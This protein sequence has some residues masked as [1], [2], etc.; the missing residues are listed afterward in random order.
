[1]LIVKLNCRLK[2]TPSNSSSFN[3]QRPSSIFRPLRRME[4]P[5]LGFS[6][7]DMLLLH[8]HLGGL[9]PTT[10]C[11]VLNGRC[12]QCT[13][14]LCLLF[15]G[16]RQSRTSTFSPLSMISA[17]VILSTIMGCLWMVTIHSLCHHP[18]VP[19]FAGDP[20]DSFRREQ[21]GLP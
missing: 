16:V 2:S 18:R 9:T 17:T 8:L 14:A 1:M 13:S 15:L 7:T 4:I 21:Q 11:R 5:M 12:T 10:T 6:L 3:S 19:T 20:T